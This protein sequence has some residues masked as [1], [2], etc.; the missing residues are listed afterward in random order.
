MSYLI[1]LAGQAVNLEIEDPRLERR[2]K[3]LFPELK[4]PVEAHLSIQIVGRGPYD[5]RSGDT[6]Y[7]RDEAEA[8]ALW[9]LTVVLGNLIRS[10]V[11]ADVCTLHCSTVAVDGKAVLMMGGSGK[12]KTTLSLLASEECDYVGD[13]YGYL[14]LST[15]RVWH[16]RYPV[17]V[18]EGSIGLFPQIKKSELVLL[19][20]DGGRS[21]Y[22]VPNEGPA[23]G[24]AI[25][26]AIVF[27]NYDRSFKGV[28]IEDAP[29]SESLAVLLRSARSSE[30]Q[31]ILARRL[32]LL[33]ARTSPPILKVTFSDGKAAAAMLR[34]S[35]GLLASPAKGS[36]KAWEGAETPARG[37]SR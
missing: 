19:R 8:S 18:K 23:S 36:A 30:P 11:S 37:G 13:E 1:S 7:A 34:R 9:R 22:L 5:V 25:L 10:N 20:D 6:V 2:V 26:G 4:D 15:G 29:F 33:L 17:Q 32:A 16:E 21:S 14:S 24:T 35:L 31:S 12:G 3:G 27:P 28:S